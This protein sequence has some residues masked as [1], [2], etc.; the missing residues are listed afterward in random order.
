MSD[1]GLH[2][3]WCSE[4]V[5]L[6]LETRSG[7]PRTLTVN[8]EEIWPSGALFQTEEPIPPQSQLHFACG[9][10]RFR[11]K[12]IAQTLSKGLGY[13]IEIRFDPGCRWSARQYRPKHLLNPLVLLANRLFE[14]ALRKP[15]SVLGNFPLASPF[16]A[17]DSS[18]KGAAPGARGVRR[19]A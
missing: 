2:R 16:A 6:R 7:R 8:L 14:A 12:V 4:I 1:Q 19:V 5:S 13:F 9:G 17:V 3:V 11:G 10:C 15:G 18:S